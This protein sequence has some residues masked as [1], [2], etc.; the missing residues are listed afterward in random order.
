[1]ASVAEESVSTPVGPE[2]ARLELVVREVDRPGG[3]IEHDVEVTHQSPSATVGDLVDAVTA[4]LARDR[5][6]VERA[7]IDGQPVGLDQSLRSSGLRRG[8]VLALRGPV[9]GADEGGATAGETAGETGPRPMH[10]GPTR[11]LL[12][13]V[14]GPD[15]GREIELA[16]GAHV[17]GRARAVDLALDDPA[18][19]G[20]QAVLCVGPDCGVTVTDLCSPRPTRAGGQVVDRETPLPPGLPLTIGGSVLQVV[21]VD[22]D[23]RCPDG[24]TPDPRR[25]HGGSAAGWTVALHRPPPAPAP[26]PVPPVR[27][28]DPAPPP[29][30]PPSPAG[31]AIVVTL[32]GGAVVSLLLHQPAFL[33]LSSIGALGT[34][35]TALWPRLRRRVRRRSECDRTRA[36]AAAVA[37]AVETHQSAVAA[38]LRTDALELPAAVACAR[39]AGPALWARRADDPC[40]F[41]AA[42]G[43]GDRW[44]PPPVESGGDAVPDEWWAVV[45]AAGA[46]RDVPVTVDLGPGAVVGVVGP[47]AVARPL[48][49]S[50]VLQLTVAHG[51]A[52]LLVAAVTAPGSPELGWLRWLPHSRDPASGDRLVATG[53]ELSSAL[54][55][56]DRSGGPHR[57]H[58]VLVVDDPTLVAARNA[59]VRELL[60]ADR[61]SA[62]L[63][64]ADTV[65]SLPSICDVVIEARPD[66]TAAVHRPG[67]AELG[68]HVI[69]AGASTATARVVALALA[70]WHDP[71]QAAPGAGLP[72]SVPLTSLLPA[73]CATDPEVLRRGWAAASADPPL[74]ARLA[75]AADGPIELDL[76]RDGPHMLVAGTTGAGKSELLRSLVAGLAVAT[77]PDHLAFVLVDYKGGAAFD[78]CARLPHVAGVVTDL[79]ERLAERALRSLHAELRRREQL[80]RAAGAADLSAYRAGTEATPIPRLVVVVDELATLAQDLPEFV[81]SLVGVAQRG[82]SLGVHLVLATQR[83]AGAVSD[84]VRANTNLRIAL[85]VQD[86][87]DS[88]DVVGVPDA[89]SLPRHRPGR[90]V[91]RFGP[92]ECAAAQIATITGRASEDG[93]AVTV[94]PLDGLAPSA[95]DRPGAAGPSALE[96]LVD[97]VVA[98]DGRPGDRHR[99]WLPPLP[100]TLRS[101][102]LP[103]GAA[104]LLDDPDRQAQRTWRWD[105]SA[106]HL[107]CIG[108]AG[109][110]GASAL[111]TTVLA[112][113]TAVP[114]SELHIY[115]VDS[116]GLPEELADLPHVGAVI[117]RTDDEQVARLVDRLATRLDGRPSDGAPPVLLVVD[118]LPAWRQVVAERLGGEVADRLDRVLVE[119]PA[120]GVVVAATAERP[121]AL[122]LAVSGAVSERL[123]FRLGDPADALLVGLRPAAVADLPSGRAVLA[124]CGLD[125][126]IGEIEDLPGAVARVAAAW[127]S[128]PGG[129]PASPI[130]QLP[131]HV[132]VR[133]LPEPSLERAT[134]EAGG[135]EIWSLPIGLDGR[136]LDVCRVHLHPGED[137]LV[138]GTAR[139][140]RSSALVLL[141]RQVR[142]ADPTARVVTVTPRRS[143]LR[144]LDWPEHVTTADELAE[145]LSAPRA[146]GADDA[147]R[148]VLLV[149]DAELVDDPSST[150]LRLVSGG[151]AELAVVAAGR[152]DALRSAYGHWTQVLRRQR[153]G[154]LLRPTSD[155]DGDV[156]G[157]SLPRRE[158][159]APAPGRGYLV[160]DGGCALVQLAW[161]DRAW[162]G[163]AD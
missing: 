122:P 7:E 52:D 16:P 24:R 67:R 148:T 136:T 51:P 57:P 150:L 77:P 153:R 40:A 47:H 73:G 70:R 45:E 14:A 9:V 69:A 94:A 34:L 115:V 41:A 106:G 96:V 121:G 119:G 54:A 76:V 83:P 87:A 81:P 65:A 28:P 163:R 12:R 95:A 88:I 42:V 63:V 159:V 25:G 84:D 101:E 154:L 105:R 46:L 116:G 58:L 108:A 93:P 60:V 133:H 56:R 79:D 18:V 82:R 20:R 49:R 4:L 23:G 102:D 2:A 113:A 78:A 123:V 74:R 38:R 134:L 30:A 141:A 112:A 66:G 6:V 43:R 138:A 31:A 152:V 156:L 155:L 85:R 72:T 53:G 140:G 37:A 120:A 145:A 126:Q 86:A 27:L 149:D 8:S 147:A 17:V 103:D 97:A 107:L 128:D 1:M 143:P 99:P 151:C 111:S 114:P 109:G 36:A 160:F 135:R 117:A 125:V 32:T 92:G 146:V 62:A 80:L 55:G 157:V 142:A 26:L 139:S 158:S 19:S 124:G 91:L 89:A 130:D 144:A 110:G 118:G 75:V 68:E 162:N 33:I 61:S 10:A 64:A 59:P 132:A 104:G 137:L 129:Q 131:K 35:A 161:P 5:A 98:A 3:P 100:P 29:P 39:L 48:L 71:E 22:P 15:A 50:L 21:A 11:V 44:Q 90:A 127:A 13:T